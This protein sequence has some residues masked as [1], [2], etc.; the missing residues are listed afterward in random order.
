MNPQL[1]SRD[2]NK[3]NTNGH[4]DDGDVVICDGD[5]DGGEDHPPDPF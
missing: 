2:H 4:G 1:G 5:L 3:M